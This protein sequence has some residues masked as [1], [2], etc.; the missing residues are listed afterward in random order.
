MSGLAIKEKAPKNTSVAIFNFKLDALF[1]MLL[2]LLSAISHQY[3]I[4]KL[5]RLNK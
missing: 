2:N 1:I 3:Y 5:L 4:F